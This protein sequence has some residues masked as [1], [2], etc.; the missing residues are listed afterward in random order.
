MKNS[1]DT[2]KNWGDS[3]RNLIQMGAFD[4]V[5]TNPPYGSKLKMMTKNYFRIMIWDINGNL[6][7]VYLKKPQRN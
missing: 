2:P 7:V 4:L 1:L 5:L 3:T 6:K